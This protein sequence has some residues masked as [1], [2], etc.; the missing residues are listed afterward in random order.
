MLVNAEGEAI[1]TAPKAAVHGADTPLHLAFSCYVFDTEGRVLLTRRAYHKRTWPGVWTNSC[2]GH[3]LP[4]EPTVDAVV[5]R[6]SYELGLTV[7]GPDL[8][9]PRFAYRAVMADG[10]VEHEVC[11]VYRAVARGGSPSRI[12]T[13]LARP[14]GCRGRSSPTTS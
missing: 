8:V 9:L 14:G 7:A 12:P 6:L 5:R 11:P 1:G 2:C 10:T 3:P 13:R 4:G